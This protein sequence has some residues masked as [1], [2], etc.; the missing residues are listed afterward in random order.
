M[1]CNWRVIFTD[2]H[3][4]CTY[5]LHSIGFWISWL[6]VDI[7]HNG[8]HSNLWVGSDF[9]L[10]WE[11]IIRRFQGKVWEEARRD[12]LNLRGDCAWLCIRMMITNWNKVCSF[13][14]DDRLLVATFNLDSL[15]TDMQRRLWLVNDATQI[16]FLH[17][18]F[19]M[20]IKFVNISVFKQTNIISKWKRWSYLGGDILC[21]VC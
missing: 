12:W 13:D 21:E 9:L 7:Y 6:W 18:H 11:D 19:R 14:V 3:Q 2:C 4:H 1:C 17:V 16:L 5:S 10:P 15:I 8:F 20:C